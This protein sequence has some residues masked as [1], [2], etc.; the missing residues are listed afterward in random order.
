MDGVAGAYIDADDV[1]SFVRVLDSFDR[2]VP[3]SREPA[4]RYDI[5]CRRPGL[6]TPHGPLRASS[7]TQQLAL[8]NTRRRAHARMRSSASVRNLCIQLFHC[9][10]HGQCR[11]L[12]VVR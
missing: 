3:E 1:P 10:L 7:W 12:V 8:G 9:A 6:L 5:E 2:V 11:E 4:A